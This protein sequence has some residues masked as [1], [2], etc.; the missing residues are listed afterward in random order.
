MQKNGY[1]CPFVNDFDET[2]L[3]IVS[4]IFL[5]V[6][7]KSELRLKL[8]ESYCCL[9]QS[10]KWYTSKFTF[11]FLTNFIEQIIYE[12]NNICR[13]M[14]RNWSCSSWNH[15]LILLYCKNTDNI[16]IFF[17]KKKCQFVSIS[18]FI[19]IQIIASTVS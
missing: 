7:L 5:R 4:S 9:I 14:Q 3:E 12:Q 13:A 10:D 11:S 15:V 17:L 18:N 1:F 19:F 6:N 8:A 2:K 16:Y